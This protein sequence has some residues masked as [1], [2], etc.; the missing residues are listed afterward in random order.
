MASEISISVSGNLDWPDYA[1]LKEKEVADL[2]LVDAEALQE[3]QAAVALEKQKAEQEALPKAKRTP[4][5]PLEKGKTVAVFST[6]LGRKVYGAM[7]EKGAGSIVKV[8]VDHVAML[9]SHC[10]LQ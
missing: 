5:A 1:T 10:D 8:I 2:R 6:A 9:F 3:F 4:S 7:I